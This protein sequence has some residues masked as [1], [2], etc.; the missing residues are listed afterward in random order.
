MTEISLKEVNQILGDLDDLRD[1]NERVSREEDENDC[2]IFYEIY[3]I[4]SKDLYV[5]LTLQVNSYARDED[6]VSGIQF[7]KPVTKT[8][9]AYENI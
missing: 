2:D 7:V 8:I 5:R 3:H 4:K 6:Y 9:T 1:D